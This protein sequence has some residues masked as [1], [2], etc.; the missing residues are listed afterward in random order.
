MN[1]MNCLKLNRIVEYIRQQGAFPFDVI[2]VEE[3]L[4]EVLFSFGIFGDFGA[5]EQ[6]ILKKDLTAIA[7]Q[8]EFAEMERLTAEEEMLICP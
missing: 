7:L 6:Q 8:E 3:R 4:N 2:D 1:K 5:D